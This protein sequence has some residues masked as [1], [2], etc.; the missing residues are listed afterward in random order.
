MLLVGLPSQADEPKNDLAAKLK[1]LAG[2]QVLPK[3]FDAA[4]LLSRDVRARIREANLHDL[5]EWRKIQT[6][7]DWEKFRDTRIAALKKSLGTFP[8]PPKDLRMRIT[9]TIDG[10]G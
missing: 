2:K 9:K 7:E 10:D 3:D 6:K 8:G 1:E 5:E 4:N